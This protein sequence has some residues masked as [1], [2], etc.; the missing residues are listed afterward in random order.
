M[1]KIIALVLALV[2]IAALFVGCK[3]D[4]DTTDADGAKTYKIIY[5]TPSTASDFWSQVETGIQQAKKDYEAKLGIKIDYTVMGPAQEVDAEGYVSALENAISQNPDAIL[6][7]TLNIDP[8]VPKAMEATNAGIILNFVNCGI[9]NGDMPEN[10]D[11]YNQFY[12][13]SNTTIGEMAA[14]AFLTAMGEKGLSTEAGTIG[15]QMNMENAALDYRM[16]GFRDYVAANAPGL[17]MTDIQYNGND[18]A[19]A[20]ADA[21]GTISAV[22]DLIGFYAGNNVT[23]DGVC[24]ALRAADMKEG[25]VSVGVD[26]DDVEIAAL[27]DG[28]LSAIIVQDAFTQGYKCMENAILTAVEGKNPETTKEYNVPPV[29]VTGANI[30]SEEIQFMMSP[31]VK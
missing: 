19:D 18:S 4:K 16:S 9:C 27:R 12:Y 25:V 10:Q 3:S 15:M 30:D 1:K 20:Q 14:Q 29:I 28:Y 13:C 6:T 8:T 22:T 17:T 5:V 21:E 11:Y 26:S 23:C 7:A 31:Y 2:M 24:N